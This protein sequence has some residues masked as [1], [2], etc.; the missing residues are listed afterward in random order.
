MTGNSALLDRKTELDEGAIMNR[1]YRV[2]DAAAPRV[3]MMFPAPSPL[4]VPVHD[5]GTAATRCDYRAATL[6]SE[7]GKLTGIHDVLPATAWSGKKKVPFS[8]LIVSMFCLQ[9]CIF[10][11]SLSAVFAELENT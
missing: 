3:E 4:D 5:V 6:R 10:F 7:G 11:R 1:M 2:C 8:K 9:F